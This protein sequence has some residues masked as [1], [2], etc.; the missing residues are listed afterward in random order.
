VRVEMI[1]IIMVKP[2]GF[3]DGLDVERVRE[4]SK[5]LTRAT[6]SL[7]WSTIGEWE[8]KI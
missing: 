2:I 1:C 3:K 6:A 5:Q 4:M 7:G 8:E